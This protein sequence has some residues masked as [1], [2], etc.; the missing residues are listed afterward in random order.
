MACSTLPAVAQEMACSLE[1]PPKTTAMRGLR[2]WLFL[3]GA[4]SWCAR[5]YRPGQ[6]PRRLLGWRHVPRARSPPPYRPATLAVTA[7]R[8]PHDARQPAQRAADDG[9]DLRR[10]RRRGVRPLRQPDL[11]GVR[12]GARRPRGRPVPGVLLRARR[13]RDDPRPGRAGRKVVAPRH[14]YNGSIMQIADLEARGRITARAGRH[15]R[16]RRR[17]EGLRG[18]RAGVAGVA[19]QPGAGGRRHRRRS[20]PPRTRPAPT[21]SSTTPSPPPCCSSRCRSDADLVVHSATKFI[22]GH[23]DVLLGAVV[24]RDDAAATTCSRSAAT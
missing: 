10:R 14:A 19:D 24:T 1:R 6:R 16:H 8:P 20:S 11:G 15:H 18:R 4:R 3:L 12:G 23:S 2:V 7:G 9:L 13:G 5:P 22:A 17:R 21:S